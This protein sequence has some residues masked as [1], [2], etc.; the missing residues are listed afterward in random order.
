M[1][2]YL[3]TAK[4]YCVIS[5]RG[6]R[7]LCRVIYEGLMEE[8]ERNKLIFEQLP[9]PKA[10]MTMAMPMIISQLII[11]I[12]NMAD[13]YFIGRTSDPFKIGGAALRL[14]LFNVCIAFANIAGTGGGTLIAR[15]L[16]VSREDEAKKVSAFSFWF[17]LT[18]ALAFALGTALLMKPILNALGASAN[19]FDYARQYATCVIVF[20]AIPTVLSMTLGGLIRNSGYAKQ[21]G[22]GV[23]LGGV[24]N[25]ILD[26]LFMFVILPRGNEILGAG[27]ATALSN[28]ISCAYFVVVITRM[29]SNVLSFSPRE[30]F[31]DKAHIKSFFAVGLAAATGPFLFDIGYILIDRLA[32]SYNDI[33]LAAIGIV[34][35]AERFPLNVGVGLCLG[36]VPLAAYNYSAGNYDRMRRVVSFAR[37]TG[38]IVALVSIVIYEVFASNIMRFFIDNEMTIEIGA[39]FL[40]IRALATVLM[41]MCFV[42]VHFFQAIG[43]G[44]I[45]FALVVF[46]WVIVNIPVLYLFNYLF[47]MYGIV[48]S[49]LASDVLVS[50]VSL[51][52][53]RRCV[54]RSLE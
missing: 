25:I 48:W 5:E 4:I 3:E 23:S 47:G 33:A 9:V 20:G 13:V 7:V 35:K 12:Y 1:D 6:I 46:R 16:G 43:K 54:P 32:A 36:M 37:K 53:Y 42:Y 29:K 24:M 40:R 50:F 45:S 27:I 11:L 52:V 39:K 26:P 10:V 49:Q 31:P 44:H 15:L 22:F 18:A 17:T 34:L 14:P 28:V 30:L 38:V 8:R 2:I 21:A 51:I 41:F 19:T